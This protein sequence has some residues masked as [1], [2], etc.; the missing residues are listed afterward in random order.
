M[1]YKEKRIVLKNGTDCIL[2]S[3]RP[4]DAESIL[5]NW[6]L[7]SEETGFMARYPEEI[8]MSIEAEKKFLADQQ[9]DPKSLMIAAV[10]YGKIVANAG[11]SCV[12]NN[13]K[14]LHRALFG[15]SI[16]KEYWNIGIG[17]SI[18]T[19]LIEWAKKAD[20]EQIE[21]EVLCENE[22]AIALYKKLGFEIYGN[23]EKSFKY[24]DGT[25]SSEF[26]MLRRL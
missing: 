17:G 21:L 15:I 10:I 6:K 11:I 4:E 26:L 18:L 20:Y 2:R 1:I 22:R 14:F 19:E 7:T 12:Q 16:Q 9:T 3:P 23:R 24:K 13:I 5:S 25:Y 8:T